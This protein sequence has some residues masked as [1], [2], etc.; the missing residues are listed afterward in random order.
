[1]KK[2]GEGL[3]SYAVSQLGRPY[4]YG[5]FG[6]TASSALLRSKSEQYPQYY[7]ASRLSGYKKQFGKRVHDCVGLVKG[8]L[9]SDSPD[10]EPEY[11]ASQDVSSE[12]MRALCREK[13]KM[14]D[15]PEIPGLLVFSDGHMGVYIG[16][17]RVIEARGFDYGVIETK[18]GSRG[19]EEWGRCPWVSYSEESSGT[20][21]LFP[22]YT[23]S[24]GSIAD[25]L[26]SIGAD[27]SYSGRRLIAS[28][29]GVSG[30]SGTP[31]QNI[32]L[33][34]KLKSGSLIKP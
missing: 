22:A 16:G 9:W 30:Y 14:S 5:T 28:V 11:D 15:M 17:G 6:Q 24:S 25:A 19:W 27:G 23:G 20:K 10:S 12:G 8:Y 2:T 31:E 7:T 21:N 26:K 34:D 29:N 4:W 32:L 33:L 13:G 1:M 18:V 3:A